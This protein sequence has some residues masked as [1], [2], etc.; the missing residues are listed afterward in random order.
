MHDPEL[1]RFKSDIHLAQYAIERYGYRR[2]EREGSRQ[3]QVLRHPATGDKIIVRKDTDGHWTYFSIRDDQDNGTIVDFV[4][5]RARHSSLGWVRQELRGWLGTARPEPEPWLPSA[6]PVVRAQ[7]SVAEAF[8]A[9]RVT[10]TS[11]YLS[12]RGLHRETLID[13]RFAGTWRQDARG[14]VL[15]VHKGVA[16]EVTGFEIKGPCFTGFA[17]GGSKTAWQSHILPTDQSLV[18][19]ESAI[20]ALSYHQLHPERAPHS[21]YLSTAGAPSSRQFAL[22]E[23]LFAELAA[24]MTIVAAVDADDAGTKLAGRIQKL[25]MG[26]RHVTFRRDSPEGDKDWNDV[27][28]RLEH[29]S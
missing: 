12:A 18:I 11:A 4:A 28:K 16:G 10:P 2:D 26:Y 24:G 20:D 29:A 19:T 8:A 3:S 14:S 6:P 23:H 17:A 25:T 27:L 13:P 9:A 1:H 21:R 5:H 22:L 7:R 15:F